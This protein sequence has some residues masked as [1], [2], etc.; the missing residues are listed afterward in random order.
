MS[1]SKIKKLN[2]KAVKAQPLAN[3]WNMGILGSDFE[4]VRFIFC[5]HN[6]TLTTVCDYYMMLDLDW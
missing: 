5:L 2:K 4:A 1:L 6:W 3:Q